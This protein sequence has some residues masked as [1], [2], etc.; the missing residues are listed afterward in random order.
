MK[1]IKVSIDNEVRKVVAEYQNH[2]ENIKRFTDR[3]VRDLILI[4]P[5]DQP[6]GEVGLGEGWVGVEMGRV[7]RG[8]GGGGGARL[9]L[10]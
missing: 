10:P 7:E 1:S 3:S 9:S 8:V 2:N 5:V 4:Y 6:G